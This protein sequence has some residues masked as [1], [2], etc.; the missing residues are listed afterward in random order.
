MEHRDLVDLIRGGVSGRRWADLGAGAGAFT[1][2]L[3]DLLGEGAEIVAVDKDRSALAALEADLAGRPGLTLRVLHADFRQDL[4]LSGLDGVLMANS[5]HFLRDKAPVLAQVLGM[6]A[7]G[8]TLLV[9]EYGSDR[10]N[11]WVPH[12]F[13]YRTWL[14][15]AAAAG[16]QQTRLV[17]ERPS[18][19][20]GSMYAAASLKP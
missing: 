17:G 15:M 2:A 7:P 18:R 6:L 16:F 9:V 3:A 11:P 19:H 14:G 5:L 10:G 1:A 13:S 20:L 12:P 4:G 8:G